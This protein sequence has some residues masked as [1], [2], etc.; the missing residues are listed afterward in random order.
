MEMIYNRVTTAIANKGTTLPN[1]AEMD[2]RD[3]R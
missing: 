1:N 3:K 2:S